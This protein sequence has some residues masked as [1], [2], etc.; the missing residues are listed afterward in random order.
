MDFNV[1]PNTV[2]GECVCVMFWLAGVIT[3][4]SRRMQKQ[5]LSFKQYWTVDAAHSIASMFVSVAMLILFYVNKQNS[6]FMYFAVGYMI[7]SFI[8]KAEAQVGA[9]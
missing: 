6:V 9:Q 3:N 5:G 1:D 8:N 4:M 2:L 7:D